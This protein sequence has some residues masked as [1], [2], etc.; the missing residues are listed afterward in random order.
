MVGVVILPFCLIKIGY[1]FTFLLDQKGKKKSRQ[2]DASAHRPLRRPAVLPGRAFFFSV[3]FFVILSLSKDL[4]GWG[5]YFSFLLDQ[6]GKIYFYSYFFLD[7][8]VGKNSRQNDASAQRPLR[9]PAVLPGPAFYRLITSFIIAGRHCICTVAS[10]TVVVRS[11]IGKGWVCVVAVR[12]HI[13]K[14]AVYTVAVRLY[15]SAVG[16][17]T[18]TV[19]KC[20]NRVRPCTATASIY[21]S[22][23]AFFAFRAGYKQKRVTKKISGAT[24]YRDRVYPTCFSVLF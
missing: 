11:F 9:R 21:K 23:L 4:L 5:C 8:K 3:L 13:G 22:M 19:E 10:F 15:I 14:V 20:T 12:V 7:K 17:C 6:K 24:L 16:H 1:Y 2:N 18:A